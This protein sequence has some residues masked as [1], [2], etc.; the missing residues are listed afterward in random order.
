MSE[1]KANRYNEQQNLVTP[2]PI[3][4]RMSA[5]ESNV[6]QAWT[7]AAPTINIEQ[8]FAAQLGADERTSGMDRSKSLLLR[9]IPLF[10]L[11]LILGTICAVVLCLLIEMDATFSAI[12]GLVLFVW[13]SYNSYSGADERE[14]YDSRNGVEHHRIDVAENVV[15]KRM[16]L[17][18][19]MKRLALAATLKQLEIRNDDDY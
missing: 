16:A 15:L 14:R 17:D 11:W 8:A 18:Y 5:E 6:L 4:R 12:A 1:T 3:V 7:Q 19:E 13:M 10:G 9:M 2:A